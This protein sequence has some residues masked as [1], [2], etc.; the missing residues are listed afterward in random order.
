MRTVVE[1]RSSISGSVKTH[2][3]VLP[4]AMLTPGPA[5]PWEVPHAWTE[6][7]GEGELISPGDR[8]TEDCLK[9]VAPDVT[10]TH[11]VVWDEASS[12]SSDQDVHC[13]S[14]LYSSAEY[15]PHELT[16]NGRTGQPSAALDT[17]SNC[18]KDF[19]CEGK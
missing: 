14:D 16:L 13:S 19:P 2:L 12:Q 3:G 11:S 15:G 6:L 5:P 9:R 1:E 17:D 7:Q 8:N 18:L 10:T 4:R